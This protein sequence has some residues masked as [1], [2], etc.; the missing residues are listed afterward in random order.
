M[1]V[2]RRPLQPILAAAERAEWVIDA[3]PASA[4][5]GAVRMRKLLALL[6]VVYAVVLIGRSLAAGE[7]P[8]V[9]ELTMVMLSSALLTGRGGR[10]LRDW[11][12]VLLGLFG[13]LLAGSFA[14]TLSFTVHYLPQVRLERLLGG[15]QIPTVWLQQHL[16]HGTPGALDIALSLV[17]VSHFFVPIGFAFALWWWRRGE[18]FSELLLTLVTAGVLA[19]VTYVLLPTAPPWLA[20]KHG[21]IPEVHKILKASLAAMHLGAAAAFEGNPRNYNIVAAWPSLHAAFPIITLVVAVRVRLPRIVIALGVLHAAAMMFAIVYL[22]EH[23]VVD[24]IGG[25]AY[26]V[27]AWLLVRAMLARRGRGGGGPGCGEAAPEPDVHLTRLTL[28]HQPAAAAPRA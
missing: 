2:L 8:T 12:L 18:G 21:Y 24:V 10:F 13:Y 27:A 9:L 25:V 22:G 28:P 14:S 16:Y 4:S 3:S 7:L 1:R 17:Y 23:Y 19:L 26:G 20:A 15:G 6:F 11:G 5:A